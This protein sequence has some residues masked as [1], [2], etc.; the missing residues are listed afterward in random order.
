MPFNAAADISPVVFLDRA[1]PSAVRVAQPLE[2]QLLKVQ[3]KS[4]EVGPLQK[5][6]CGVG[7]FTLEIR[8]VQ[9]LLDDALASMVT[10]AIYVS[11][12][13]QEPAGWVISQLQSQPMCAR[14]PEL[15]AP[16]CN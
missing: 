11:D 9:P 2:S 4:P 8:F 7:M 3:T 6:Y 13:A 10:E 12:A 5:H 15:F 14:G 1:D 16:N